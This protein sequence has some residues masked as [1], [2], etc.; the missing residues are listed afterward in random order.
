MSITP[1]NGL[2]AVFAGVCAV[3]FIYAGLYILF[4]DLK[5]KSL[6]PLLYLCFISSA[7][8]FCYVMYYL[9][10]DLAMRELWRRMCFAGM[11]NMV[12]FLWFFMN[13][14]GFITNKKTAAFLTAAIWVPPLIVLYKNFSE[15]AVLRDFPSGFW[16]LY[17]EIQPFSYCFVS[18]VLIYIFCIR[19][20]TNKGRREAYILCA[21]AIVLLLASTAAD[22]FFGIHGSQNIIPFWVLLWI[23]ALLFTIKKYRF[24]TISPASISSDIT[25]NI[26]EGTILLDP[27]LNIIYSN[28]AARHLFN[29]DGAESIR[30]Q[31]FVFESHILDDELA[32][33]THTG[34]TSFRVRIN[35]IPRGIEHKL[36]VDMKVKKIIDTYNDPSGFLIIVSRAKDIEHLKSVYKLTRREVEVIHQLTAGKTNKEIADF[37]KITEK[38]IETHIANIYG[39]LLIKNRIELINIISEFN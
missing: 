36:P 34:G 16:F 5:D 4:T 32:K 27:D 33:L 19:S 1:I 2:S 24:I 6:R 15:N 20:K 25:D 11:S 3:S 35:L 8:S 31:D 22:Y 10:G 9:T 17:A 23:G 28:R 29:A 26:E 13:Y 39:K 37:L 12:F 14:T 7:W 38:T 18:I 30:L 21:S